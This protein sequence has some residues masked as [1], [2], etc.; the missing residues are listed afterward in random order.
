MGRIET[1][2]EAGPPSTAAA[3]EEEED[4]PKNSEDAVQTLIDAVQELIHT[5]DQ[6]ASA[7]DGDD[8]N[9]VLITV[10]DQSDKVGQ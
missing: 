2:A 6:A 9:Q 10:V 7:T 1:A 8:E 3:A 4:T 5:H